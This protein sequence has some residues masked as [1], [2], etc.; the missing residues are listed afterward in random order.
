MTIRNT[1]SRALWSGGHVVCPGDAF[2]R[3]PSMCPEWDAGRIAWER[4]ELRADAVCADP[5]ASPPVA[6]E[7]GR[8]DGLRKPEL[9]RLYKA[10]G[11]SGLS[12]RGATEDQLR[13]ELEGVTHGD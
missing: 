11:L 5:P 10:A 7:D 1:T 4:G 13:A 3:D 12:Y 8:L 2:P 9:W 6:C